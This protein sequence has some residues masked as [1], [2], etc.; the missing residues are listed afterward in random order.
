M[1]VQ[2]APL[3]QHLCR[4]RRGP[5]SDDQG[6]SRGSRLP[7]YFREPSGVL[8]EIATD[9]PGFAVDE[10]VD[11]LGEKLS[12]AVSRSAASAD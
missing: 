3:R 11:R 10:P 6:A 8:F 9:G 4:Y 12:A 7:L 2:H 1:V 5:T